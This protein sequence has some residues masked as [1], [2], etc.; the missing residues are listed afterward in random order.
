MFGFCCVV[1][2]QHCAASVSRLSV[3]CRRTSVRSTGNNFE[4]IGRGRV[5]ILC[6]N[7]R[8][9]AEEN[10]GHLNQDSRYPGQGSN[11]ALPETVKVT[12][13]SAFCDAVCTFSAY[14]YYKKRQ[15][16]LFAPVF[17][18]HYRWLSANRF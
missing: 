10:H 17:W 12:V 18:T 1:C 15:A 14:S 8:E 5:D 9:R 4:E 11:W 16:F 6:H 13:I 7:L 3:D 2:L